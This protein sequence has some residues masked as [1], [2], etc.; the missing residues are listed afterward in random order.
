[1]NNKKIKPILGLVEE[2]KIYLPNGKFIRRQAKIDTG[3]RTTAI[4]V[5]IAKKI[6]LLS[7]YEEFNKEMPKLKIT[8][9]NFK[10]IK[11]KIRTVLAP[12]LKKQIPGLYDI[13]VIPATNGITVRPFV[14]LE[15]KMRNKKIETIASIVD[16]KMLL[17]PILIGK[18]DMEGFL[19][20]PTKNIYRTA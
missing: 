12:K 9:K 13:R 17:Y 6:G 4:D 7:V 1:M 2:V 11:K 18:R 20:D 19:I 15:Y 10:E 14:K 3:A 5:S 16:R 8:T